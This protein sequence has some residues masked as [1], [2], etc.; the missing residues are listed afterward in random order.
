MSIG[1]WFKGNRSESDSKEGSLEIKL[2]AVPLREGFQI[3]KR[4]FLGEHF[5]F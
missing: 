5:L 3:L 4:G 1:R 2:T